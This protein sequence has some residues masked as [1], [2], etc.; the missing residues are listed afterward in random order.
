MFSILREKCAV[1]VNLVLLNFPIGLQC[2]DTNK[3]QN[4]GGG[5]QLLLFR[6]KLKAVDEWSTAPLPP[7]PL[8]PKTL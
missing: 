5:F 8:P 3:Y 1:I 7:T 6:Y 4:I 2:Q